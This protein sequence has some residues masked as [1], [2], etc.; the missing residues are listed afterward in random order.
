MTKERKQK[1]K[2]WSLRVGAGFLA[3]AA[4][5]AATFFLVPGRIRN[6]IFDE[7]EIEE[8]EETHFSKFVTRLMNAIDVES[9]VTSQSTI[10]KL[11]PPAADHVLTN[12][13][14]M[15]LFSTYPKKSRIV[16]SIVFL[17]FCVNDILT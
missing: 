11:T 1:I 13:L 8:V 6:I 5:L 17:L 9:M 4:G 15:S 3:F 12:K 7:P 10:L 2:K 16:T 14:T